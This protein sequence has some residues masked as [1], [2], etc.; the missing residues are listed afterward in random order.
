MSA[1]SGRLCWAVKD[2]F[3]DY[4]RGL[5]DGA[6]D[7]LNGCQEAGESFTFPRESVEGNAQLFSGGIRFT[8]FAGMLDVRLVDLMIEGEERERTL[9]ALVGPESIAARVTIAT[10]ES[11]DPLTADKPWSGAPRLT[12]E[13]TRVFGDVYPVGTELAQLTV[14]PSVDE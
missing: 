12:F 13:G 11:S 4:V 8:G 7:L 1:S 9:S 5:S 14:E 6:I 10:V 2:S 3:L